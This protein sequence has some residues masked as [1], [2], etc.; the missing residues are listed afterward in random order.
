M[1]HAKA[2]FFTRGVADY[3]QEVGT[4]SLNGYEAVISRGKQPKQGGEI[5]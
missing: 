1:C 2:Y 4:H 3:K 5:S